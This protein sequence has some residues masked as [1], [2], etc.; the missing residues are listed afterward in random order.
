MYEKATLTPEFS[1]VRAPTLRSDVRA[2]GSSLKKGTAI[3]RKGRSCWRER[4]RL[5]VAGG[6]LVEVS[7]RGVLRG[8]R[9]AGGRA[10]ADDGVRVDEDRMKSSPSILMPEELPEMI[11][12]H[13]ARVFA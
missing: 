1:R 10:K 3:S 7:L 9:R 5:E 8:P 4:V 11:G 6:A 13:S 2:L 12:G